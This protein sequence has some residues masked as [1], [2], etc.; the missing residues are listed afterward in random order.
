MKTVHSEPLGPD[1]RRT[2]LW[3]SGQARHKWMTQKD[4][5][6]QMTITTTTKG[7]ASLPRYFA[8]AFETLK[9]MD[10]GSWIS[11]C[12]MV[13]VSGPR[14]QSRAGGRTARA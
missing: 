14:R 8:P 7:E 3:K 2:P 6:P 1:P 9:K 12:P 5:K 13:G 11:S 4:L 10:H